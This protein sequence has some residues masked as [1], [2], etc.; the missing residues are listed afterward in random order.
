[1][2]GIV[3][4]GCLQYC[5]VDPGMKLMHG[6]HGNSMNFVR[7]TMLFDCKKEKKRQGP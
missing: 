1:M 5:N 6:T 4:D 7:A 2:L 3:Y